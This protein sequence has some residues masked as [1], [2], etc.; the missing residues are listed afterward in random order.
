VHYRS[1]TRQQKAAQFGAEAARQ[2]LQVTTPIA[3]RYTDQL[4]VTQ[5]EARQG[6]EQ[7]AHFTSC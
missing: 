2:G 3:E 5:Q 1:I 7:V 6:F 4:G